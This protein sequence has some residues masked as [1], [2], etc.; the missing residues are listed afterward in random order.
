VID[1]IAT[2]RPHAAAAAIEDQAFPVLRLRCEGCSSGSAAGSLD[3]IPDG[4]PMPPEFRCGVCR[5][6]LMCSACGRPLETHHILGTF[7]FELG[8]KVE[9]HFITLA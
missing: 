5:R 8:A 7:L 2:P 1:A 6:P 9:P 3:V 4:A